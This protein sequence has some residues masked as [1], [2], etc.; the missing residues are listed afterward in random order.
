MPAKPESAPQAIAGDAGVVVTWTWFS[1][2][3]RILWLRGRLLVTPLQ[4]PHRDWLSNEFHANSFIYYSARRNEATKKSISRCISVT[5]RDRASIITNR[6]S[7]TGSR[8]AANSMTLNDLERQNRWFYGFFWQFR[9]ATQVYIIH[10]VA[11]RNYRCAIQIENLVFV[12]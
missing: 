1:L 6:K 10:K 4:Y 11:P 8:L 3:R 5:M 2:R 7:Y 9:S 12:Y